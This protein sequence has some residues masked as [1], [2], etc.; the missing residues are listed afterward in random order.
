VKFRAEALR[1]G[2]SGAIM[3]LLGTRQL[4]VVVGVSFGGTAKRDRDIF[5]HG[6]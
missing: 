2:D 6:Y 1:W 5:V 3:C 4:L